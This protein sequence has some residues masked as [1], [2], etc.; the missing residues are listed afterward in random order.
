MG[1]VTALIPATLRRLEAFAFVDG[2]EELRFRYDFDTSLAA[3][4]SCDVCSAALG[5]A[6]SGFW[7]ES[8]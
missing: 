4:V 7:C 2:R 6:R 3:F 8:R 5:F 1:H